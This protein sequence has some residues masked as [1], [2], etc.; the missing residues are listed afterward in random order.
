MDVCLGED[1]PK[2]VGLSEDGPVDDGP[3]E[4]EPA[5]LSSK[6]LLTQTTLDTLGLRSG[7]MVRLEAAMA[8]KWYQN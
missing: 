2:D 7:M 8:A 1:G 5:G 3:M 4:D 6:I